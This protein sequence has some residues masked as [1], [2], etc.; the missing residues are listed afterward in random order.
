MK[1]SRR[2]SYWVVALL[3][4][5]GVVLLALRL[6]S[7]YQVR[8]M[9]G[10]STWRLTYHLS[11]RAPNAGTKVRIAVPSDDRHSRVF[12]QDLRYSGLNT[13]R[14]RPSRSDT[15]ELSAT[16]Q[17]DGA[18][19]MACRFDIH[20]SPTTTFRDR[21]APAALTVEERGQYLRSTKTIQVDNP[22]VTQSIQRLQANLA[23]KADLVEK[24]FD[25]CQNE[26]AAGDVGAPSD[27]AGVLERATATPLG[28][29]RTMVALCRAGKVPAR[30]V[31]GFEIWAGGDVK[32]HVWVETLANHRWEPYDPDNGFAHE[33]PHNYLAAR[34]GG[35]EIIHAPEASDL[36]AAY[37]LTPIP[38]PG[39]ALG[40]K[41]RSPLAILDL[42]RLPLE[43][44]EVLELILLMP[45]G[46][47]LTSFFRT[48]V[49]VRTYGTF[50]P[51]LLALAFCFADWRTGLMIFFVVVGL[52]LVAR[53]MLDRL[54]LLMVPRLS[55]IL[56]LVAL[57]ILFAVSLLDYLGAT[58]SAQA[59]LLPMV[60]LTMT[61]ERFYVTAEEDGL[62]FAV[63]LL[64]GTLAVGFFCY[65][66]LR[67]QTVGYLL[68]IHPEVHLF[69]VALLILMGRY[70]GYRLTELWRFRDF[71]ET[72]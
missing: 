54:R 31:A 56:T 25:Y 22:I 50:T 18:F 67:W 8:M 4:A 12:R 9:Q 27:A 35:A 10:D 33:M 58:P 69:T 5:V 63:Q 47:L 23:N 49:G 70:T 66:I 71:G 6:Y 59:V 39:G 20:L 11:F 1:A 16:T 53:S 44:H 55:V 17:R 32:P 43:M 34:R 64:A 46:A 40:R 48:L 61:I 60:I 57:C 2:G 21:N 65:L 28:R 26:I 38:P 7:R 14:M 15:R 29:A 36:R 30:L 68:L 72:R 51:T 62:R 13:E 45:L 37:T 19:R 41:N 52:G 42:A 24:V 3:I